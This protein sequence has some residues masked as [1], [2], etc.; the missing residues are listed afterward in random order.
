VDT[1]HTQVEAADT[2]PAWAEA[3]IGPALVAADTLL[4]LAEAHIVPAPVLAAR[5]IAGLGKLRPAERFAHHPQLA[6]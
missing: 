1:L 6:R 3:R 4:P 2:L 5:R